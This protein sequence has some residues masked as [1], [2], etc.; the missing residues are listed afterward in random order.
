MV[1]F[2]AMKA[3]HTQNSRQEFKRAMTGIRKRIRGG[4]ALALAACLVVGILAP[5]SAAENYQASLKAGDDLRAENEIEPAL[6]EYEAALQLA[7]TPT[8][9]GLALGKKG[10]ILAYDKKNYTEAR[11]IAQ[12]VIDMPDVRSV[13]RVTALQ[14]LAECQMRDE[15]N[16]PAAVDTLEQGLQ[17][18]GVPW[19]LPLLTLMLGDSYR[20]SGK[21]EKALEAF[22]QVP[23]LAEAGDGIK[24]V[25]YLNIG[26]T[27]Q[28]NLHDADAAKE[29]YTKAAGLNPGLKKEID[30]HL[31]KLP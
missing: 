7:T 12:Q 25:A 5:L 1:M 17:L 9:R 29:A 2:L 27:Q 13:A 15:K 19:A 24:G 16:Y 6:V 14:V 11:D 10:M 30:E 20:F 22:E 23:G 31:A 8:E 3:T 26:L 28:Y 18:E 21:F 4:V